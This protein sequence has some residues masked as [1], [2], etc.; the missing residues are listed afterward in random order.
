[1]VGCEV[2]WDDAMWYDGIVMR[3]GWA[4]GRS[5]CFDNNSNI[6][7]DFICFCMTDNHVVY[8]VL[9]IPWIKDILKGNYLKNILDRSAFRKQIWYKFD[10]FNN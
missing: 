6:I 7:F 5:I 3:Y 1:M 8:K 2:R 4:I 10:L 9:V